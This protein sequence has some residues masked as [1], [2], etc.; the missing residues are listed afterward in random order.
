MTHGSSHL[1]CRLLGSCSMHAIG[2]GIACLRVFALLLS[3]P[4]SAPRLPPPYPARGAFTL[5]IVFQ[6]VALAASKSRTVMSPLAYLP[7]LA[8]AGPG[9]S[10]FFWPPSARPLALFSPRAP[11]W[12]L[13]WLYLSTRSAPSQPLL[14]QPRGP[15]VWYLR[16]IPP[17][18]IC[19]QCLDIGTL[20]LFDVLSSVE[21]D[22]CPYIESLH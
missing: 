22:G 1:T 2:F 12:P 18:A 6:R 8:P 16:L 7:V 5:P 17:S 11:F 9:L 14:E 20:H 15:R 10:W 19:L 21:V 13:L 3:L 4:G